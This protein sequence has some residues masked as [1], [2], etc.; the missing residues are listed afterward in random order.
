MRL[1]F[2]FFTLFVGV[3]SSDLN[4]IKQIKIENLK[5]NYVGKSIEFVDYSN[6]LIIRGELLNI[7]DSTFVVS[8][9][10][11]RDVFDINN[12]RYFNLVPEAPDYIIASGVSLLSAVA[13]YLS[14]VILLPNPAEDIKSTVLIAGF[15]VGGYIGKV[16]FLKPIKVELNLKD[17]NVLYAK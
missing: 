11:S 1:A 10:G 7:T 8:S 14:L 9:A 13:G 3:R 5:K 6:S 16:S 17:L 4:T 12:I 2:L 15:V